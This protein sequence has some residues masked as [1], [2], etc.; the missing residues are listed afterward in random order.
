MSEFDIRLILTNIGR[1]LGLITG[2]CRSNRSV[3]EKLPAVEL[4]LIPFH[5]GIENEEIEGQEM[6]TAMLLGRM[7]SPDLYD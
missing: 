6:D 4:A 1:K 2:I 5:V 7:D 3:T